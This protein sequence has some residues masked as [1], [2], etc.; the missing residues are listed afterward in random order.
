LLL[1]L[2]VGELLVSRCKMLAS[3]SGPVALEGGP[4]NS[5]VEITRSIAIDAI[6]WMRLDEFAM[7]QSQWTK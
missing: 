3:W 4:W 6:D 1:L 2:Q 7:L 5:S